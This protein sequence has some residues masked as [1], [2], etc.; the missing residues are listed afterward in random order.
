ML[1]SGLIG[2]DGCALGR[3][4]ICLRV[5]F[6]CCGQVRGAVSVSKSRLHI[7]ACGQGRRKGACGVR[8]HPH[9]PAYH[10]D[11]KGGIRGL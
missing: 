9:A 3:G 6:R 7:S 1:S 5:R 4:T 2:M 11:V 10:G 8:S